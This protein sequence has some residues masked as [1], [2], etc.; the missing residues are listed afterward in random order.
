MK[1]RS[2]RELREMKGKR[3]L[4]RVDFN[5]KVT[6]GNVAREDLGRLCAAVPTIQLLLQRGA[7]V[8]IVTHL[9]EP[10][11]RVCPALSTRALVKTFSKLV[12]KPVAFVSQVVGASVTH[13]VQKLLPGQVL[14]LE[15]LRFDSREEK[16][17]IAFA[18]ALATTA[19]VYV[20]DAFS[21]SHREHASL[22]AIT[23]LLP[24]YAG[25]HLLGE[26]EKLDRLLSRPRKP[27]VVIVG[28]A[29]VSTKLP[30]IQRLLREADAVLIGGALANTFLAA[31]GITTGNSF[32]EETCIPEAQ[33]LLK[34]GKIML[35]LDVRVGSVDGK[36]T[37]IRRVDAIRTSE[38][39]FDI[40]PATIREF[41]GI[42]SR[43]Q[44]LVWN[45]PVGRVEVSAYAHGTRALIRAFAARVRGRAYGVVGGGDTIPLFSA[46]SLASK[47]DFIS[48]GGGAMLQYLSGV[49]LPGLLPL[50]K[51]SSH[52]KDKK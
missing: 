41:S 28:G 27:F 6:Q 7:R 10:N 32:V 26:V 38:K 49:S 50:E 31:V 40:G 13:A 33:R 34:N 9:G 3:V 11:G 47:I 17:S 35:P 37:M 21:V 15:N 45:G 16:N 2:I 25:L 23:Q 8:I 1:L 30:V 42:I 29:K 36:K 46:P 12:G 4:I 18:R 44:T 24:S 39:V 52:G 51:A 48:T 19:D 20:N 43:A 14:L 5:V 22:V